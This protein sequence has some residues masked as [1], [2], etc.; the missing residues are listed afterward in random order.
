M[1]VIKWG[2]K[3]GEEAQQCVLNPVTYESLSEATLF[4]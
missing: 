4:S 2:N 3:V 1:G